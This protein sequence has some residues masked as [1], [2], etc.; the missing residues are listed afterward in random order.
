MT[1]ITVHE[2]GAPTPEDLESYRIA[3]LTLYAALRSK[4]GEYL[5]QQRNADPAS[6][7]WVTLWDK[8]M[9]FGDLSDKAALELKEAMWA[10]GLHTLEIP[11]WRARIVP[12]EHS[13]YWVTILVERRVA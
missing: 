11:G 2:L 9:E 13:R 7:E 5:A 6:Q 12:S 1:A 3:L 4:A 10:A 8:A